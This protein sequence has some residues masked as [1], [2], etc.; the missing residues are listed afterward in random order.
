MCVGKTYVAVT[1]PQRKVRVK[2]ERV[3]EVL[4]QKRVPLCIF[5]MAAP[6]F[7]K[8]NIKR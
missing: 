3:Y 6:G 2:S 5:F 8:L 1:M 7:A 4:V